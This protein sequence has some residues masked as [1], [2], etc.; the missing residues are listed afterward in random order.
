M[1]V[2]VGL[3][4]RRHPFDVV[5]DPALLF[6]LHYVHVLDADGPAVGV[7]QDRKDFPQAHAFVAGEIQRQELAVEIPDG[8]AVIGRVEL[9]MHVGD[10]PIER[11]QM[12]NK[13]PPHPVGV[14]EA[15]DPLLLFDVVAR[16]ARRG[17]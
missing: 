8:Q 15:V 2:L 5:L 1:S 7:P 12:S 6:G 10:P 14:H 4:R 16:P 9:G 13:V 17:R 3:Q 11:V